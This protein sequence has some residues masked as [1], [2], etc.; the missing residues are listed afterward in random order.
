MIVCTLAYTVRIPSPGGGTQQSFRLQFDLWKFPCEDLSGREYLSRIPYSRRLYYPA[1]W[2]MMHES[3]TNGANAYTPKVKFSIFSTFA[4]VQPTVN[5][6]HTRIS[7]QS[8]EILAI[9]DGSP[10]VQ[11]VSW[12]IQY[13]Q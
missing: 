5:T 9:E 6:R 1:V 8:V 7:S 11:Q 13:H 4:R 3:D 12:S 10:L 2:Y